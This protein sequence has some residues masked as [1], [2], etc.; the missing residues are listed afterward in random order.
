MHLPITSGRDNKILRAKS[1]PVKKVT[2]KILKLL[3]DMEET[4]F[5]EEGV[6]IAAPQV[7]VNLHMAIMLLDGKKVVPIIN[8][9][10]I[11]HS[12][13]TDVEQEGCLSLRGEW[14]QIERYK[15]ITIEFMNTKSEKITMKLKGFNARISQHEIDHL[16]GT[17]F[18]DHVKE[19]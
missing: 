4:M 17:L 3:K 8:P 10:I 2:K 18:V 5:L 7:G 16:N 11:E 19:K 12:E 14:G 13:K 15:E 6:G 1:A 9:K